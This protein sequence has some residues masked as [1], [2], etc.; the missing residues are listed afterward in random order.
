MVFRLGR[1]F[2]EDLVSRVTGLAYCADGSGR[3]HEK[4]RRSW[5]VDCILRKVKCDF[6]FVNYDGVR[7][8][9]LTF[10]RITASQQSPFSAKYAAS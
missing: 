10:S 7:Y 4:L 9:I 8:D 2:H 3:Y 6:L 1:W 5:E